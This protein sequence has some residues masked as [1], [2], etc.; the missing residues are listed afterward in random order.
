[1]MVLP[2]SSLALLFVCLGFTSGRALDWRQST[3]EAQATPFQKTVTLVFEFKNN[4]DKPVHLLDLQTSCSCLSAKSD[5]KVFASGETSW[6]Q[7]EFSAEEP[8]GSYER[9]INVL[10][11]ESPDPQ[12]LTVRIEIPELAVLA[13]RS[14]EWRLN[15][16]VG[17]KSIEVRATGTLRI[18]FTQSI[19][20]N[21][22]FTARLEAVECGRVYKL[23]IQPR[24]TGSVANAAIRIYG[25]DD[26]GHDILISAYANVR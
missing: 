16:D 1:M 22:S 9:H 14:V 5:K 24:R 26:N 2:R 15:E 21:D 10:T 19:P 4:G 3:L 12:R 11:D 23:I 20:S 25:H 13:P 7:A 8:P 18:D 17:E 6:I